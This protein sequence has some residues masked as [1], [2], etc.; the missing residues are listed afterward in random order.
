MCGGLTQHAIRKPVI[1]KTSS[2]KNANKPSTLFQKV[3]LK[4]HNRKVYGSIAN[5][6]AKHL[7]RPDLRQVFSPLSLLLLPNVSSNDGCAGCCFAG[8]GD[9][10]QPAGQEGDSGAQTPGGQG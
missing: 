3:E 5:A 8:L 9:S 2:K 10:V 7:Y 1:T 6:T 4:K